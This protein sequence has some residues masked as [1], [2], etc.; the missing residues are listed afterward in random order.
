MTDLD[1]NITD[2]LLWKIINSHFNEN[3]Q[4]LVTHHIE[5]YDDFYA[6][7]IQQIFREKNPVRISSKYDETIND[8]RYQCLLYFGGKEGSRI[9]FGKPVIHDTNNAH[10]MMPNEARMRNMT[11]AMT[12]HYDIEVEYVRLL[13][14]GEEPILIGVDELLNKS[15]GEGLELNPNDA[16]LTDEYK[17]RENSGKVKK[18]V[19]TGRELHAQ[20]DNYLSY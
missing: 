4:S 18:N 6:N 12:I 19:I 14:P 13:E 16:G 15:D 9:Y 5:S 10:Y 17:L 2:D 11:Y 3:P 7:G 20:L 8:Y 1:S